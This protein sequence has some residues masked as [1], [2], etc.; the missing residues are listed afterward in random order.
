MRCLIHIGLEKTGTT[1]IQSLLNRNRDALL[2]ESVFVSQSQHVGN[3]FHLALAS[4]TTFR[5]DSLLRDLGLSSLN[6]IEAFRSRQ[7][8]KLEREAASAKKLGATTFVLSSEH[9]QSRLKLLADIESFKS[10]LTQAGL[11]DFEIVVYLRN[12]LKIA[13]SHHGMAIKKGIHIDAE[14]FGPENRRVSQILN[15]DTSLKMWIQTFGRESL[16]VRLY[17]EG[18]STS[19]LLQDFIG[20]LNP[21]LEIAKLEL[22]GRENRNLSPSALQ[23]LNQL[24]SDS[25]LVKKLWDDRK[26]FKLLEEFAGGSGLQATSELETKYREHFAASN[27]WVR[28]EFF[29]DRDSLFES[30]LSTK[31]TDAADLQRQNLELTAAG[32]AVTRAALELVISQ[33]SQPSTRSLNSGT[34][35]LRRIARRIRR[36]FR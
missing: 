24:N 20:V 16:N 21:K 31:G 30:D 15:F 12:P 10:L 4:Y 17:P 28:T 19:N 27:E 25:D 35:L 2:Q 1:S 33:R 34:A 13:L 18:Q 6:D 11:N 9:F 23:I 32:A 22:P 36:F 29:K 8:E 14:A 7:V 5:G 26:F 3:N